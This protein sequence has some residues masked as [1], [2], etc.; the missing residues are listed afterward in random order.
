MQC[1]HAGVLN[2]PRHDVYT[3]HKDAHSAHLLRS[4]RRL[5]LQE[6]QAQVPQL[7][8]CQRVGHPAGEALLLLRRR[9]ARRPPRR[10]VILYLPQPEGQ[11]LCAGGTVQKLVRCGNFCWAGR[12][13]LQPASR[14][15]G[16]W[17]RCILGKR[18]FLSG[19]S[20]K[21]SPGLRFRTPPSYS[22]SSRMRASLRSPAFRS[23]FHCCAIVAA[24]I[25]AKGGTNS[26]T[27]SRLREAPQTW[28]CCNV[29]RHQR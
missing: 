25:C 20:D 28:H 10:L 11:R 4:G 6:A 18:Q 15:D 9:P 21:K 7:R 19:R 17:R 12:N 26:Q 5:R 16:R 23:W 3:R 24:R 22:M 14:Q 8:L 29:R 1:A 27:D 13:K 2:Q